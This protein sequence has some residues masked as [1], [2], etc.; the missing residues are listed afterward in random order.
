MAGGFFF[1]FLGF[2]FPVFFPACGSS[3]ALETP[4]PVQVPQSVEP[5]PPVRPSGGGGLAE[6]IRSLTENG[7][8]PSL[9]RAL[10]LIRSRDLG[11]TEF[12]RVM[13]ACNVTL[14]RAVYPGLQA[15]LPSQDP[16]QTHTYARILRDA[17]KG[18]YTPPQAGSR[19]YLE[20]TLPFLALYSETGERNASAE[21]LLVALPDLEKAAELNGAS[22]LAPY[23]MGV[24]FERGGR[25][26]EALPHYTRAWQLSPE[27]YPAALALARV[28]DGQGQKEES[29]KLLQDL[30]IRFPDNFRIKRQ[31]A[32]A[33]YN[34]R[35]WSRAEPAIA[36]ILQRDSRDREFILMRAHVLVEQ[37]QYLQAQTPLDLYASIN[38]S[39]PLYL[40][41]RARVQV[42]GYHNRDAA[43][44]YLRSLLR[45]IPGDEASVYAARLLMESSRPE[46]QAEGRELLQRLLSVPDPSLLVVALALQDAVRRESWRE[47]QPYLS[48][49]LEERRSAQDLLYAY[50]VEHGQGNNAAALSYAR[51]LYERNPSNEEGIITYISA[52]I[53]TGRQG[54]AGGMIESR[55]SALA[56]GALKSRYFYLRSRIR[57]NEESVMNDLRS[58][59]FEDPRNFNALLAMFEIYHR[60]KDER[61]AV[62]YLKQ[63]LALAPNNPQLKR[64]ETEYA[65]SLGGASY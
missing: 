12:G 14:I 25:P 13:T 65:G 37:G 42:E 44:T 46:D 40:F 32:I 55:L 58:S 2:L 5:P 35:D 24:V 9:L 45:G 49:L 56:G 38:P 43:L 57:A 39:N 4:L 20:H 1:L 8:P 22:V 29:L 11:S 50:T 48:R 53:E 51:E 36:E 59:L 33:W 34:N 15:Q 6:E 47:A 30:V 10:D 60:R 54:E 41:L 23:F 31:M 63:A 64:Y 7:S 3:P 61:R 28:Y 52:L 19:D 62:Y 21:R 16:P 18:I 17:E 26:S 27:C